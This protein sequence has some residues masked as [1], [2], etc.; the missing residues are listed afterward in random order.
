VEGNFTADYL[1]VKQ[2]NKLF[3]VFYLLAVRS[4]Q[5]AFK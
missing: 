2:E 4:G 5:A 1:S 3:C